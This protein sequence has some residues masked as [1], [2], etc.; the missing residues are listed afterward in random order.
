MNSSQFS[1]LFEL[2]FNHI[3][4]PRGIDHIVFLTVL[5][6]VY[7]WSDWK[8]LLWAIT[9]FTLGHSITLGISTTGWGSDYSGWIEFGIPLTIFLTG[10]YNLLPFASKRKGGVRIFMAGVFGLIH[11]LGFGGFFR[12]L[13]AGSESVWKDLIPFTIG[14][15]TGQITAVVGLL[16]LSG[17]FHVAFR[18]KDRD[19]LLFVSGLGVGM[20]LLMMI[21]RFPELG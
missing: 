1:S 4:D 21:E 15:E 8:T 20:S 6:A 17:L 9:A 14:I 13:S 10:L 3:L 7:R 16:I 2:G 12:M 19:W 5:V 18:M 11:G